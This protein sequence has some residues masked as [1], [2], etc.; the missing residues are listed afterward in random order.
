MKK[1]RPAS[2]RIATA[3]DYRRSL[4]LVQLLARLDSERWQQELL[5]L[6]QDWRVPHNGT[7]EDCLQQLAIHC[8]QQG[9]D[10]W[11]ENE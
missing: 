10:N 5:H 1:G 2:T 6:A 7:F 11:H 4:Y 9:R 8:D 3:Y